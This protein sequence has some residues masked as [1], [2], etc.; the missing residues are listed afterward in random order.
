M[1]IFTFGTPLT[2]NWQIAA[3]NRDLVLFPT[4]FYLW[5]LLDKFWMIHSC[6]WFSVSVQP[7]SS[8]CW[9]DMAAAFLLDKQSKASSAKVKRFLS[10][11]SDSTV[12][13]ASIL[14]I[15]AILWLQSTIVWAAFIFNLIENCSSLS[16][17]CFRLPSTL[18]GAE[19][20]RVSRGLHMHIVEKLLVGRRVQAAPGSPCVAVRSVTTCASYG[21]AASISKG[22]NL[23][24]LAS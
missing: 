10:F 5:S 24:N 21:K 12:T 7:L 15:T 11:I 16:F 23:G 18:T 8:S 14:Y 3:A 19:Q 6:F 4:Q 1:N 2:D 9:L 17:E 20:Q 22:M 13:C